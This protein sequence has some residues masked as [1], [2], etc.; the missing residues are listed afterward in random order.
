[1]ITFSNPIIQSVYRGTYDIPTSK[2]EMRDDFELMKKYVETSKVHENKNNRTCV[3][4][5]LSIMRV[6]ES[7]ILNHQK[8]YH[9][10]KQ[11]NDAYNKEI[12]AQEKLEE[13]LSN[14]LHIGTR[15]ELQKRIRS[16]KRRCRE[17]DEMRSEEFKY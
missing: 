11:V 17:L 13:R 14:T 12:E 15:R 1:M 5:C 10:R 9:T 7:Y 8:S 3:S 2:K 16:S 4:R 6:L